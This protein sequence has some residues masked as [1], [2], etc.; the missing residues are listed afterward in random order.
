MSEFPAIN[1]IEK[2]TEFSIAL[3]AYRNR[4]CGVHMEQAE[5]ESM[6]ASDILW[7]LVRA[8]FAADLADFSEVFAEE[9]RI[10]FGSD[11]E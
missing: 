5:A 7:P 11:E 2:L 6:Q 9:H 3:I 10:K 8:A 4:N 1:V